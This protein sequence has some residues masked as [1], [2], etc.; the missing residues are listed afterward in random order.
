MFVYAEVT[1]G[2]YLPQDYNELMQFEAHEDVSRYR[3]TV[4]TIAARYTVTVDATYPYRPK[5][6][7]NHD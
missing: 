3:K 7:S 5:E 2:F 6:R 1:Y 4:D